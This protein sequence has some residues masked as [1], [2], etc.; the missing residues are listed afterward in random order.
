[1][2]KYRKKGINSFD[3]LDNSFDF[4]DKLGADL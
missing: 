1:M 4:K 3:P 2:M